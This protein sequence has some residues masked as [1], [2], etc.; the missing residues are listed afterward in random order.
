M[1]YKKIRRI[2]RDGTEK[3]G[4]ENTFWIYLTRQQQQRHRREKKKQKQVREEKQH[5]IYR[6]NGISPL[7]VLSHHCAYHH[8]PEVIFSL[9]QSSQQKNI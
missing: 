2:R 9:V 8:H 6:L 1:P 7:F 4:M 5:K 3:K